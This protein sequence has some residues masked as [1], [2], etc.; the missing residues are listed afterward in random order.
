VSA[1]GSRPARGREESE[2]PANV[3]AFLRRNDPHA[4]FERAAIRARDGESGYAGAVTPE[5]AWL[6][7]RAG[8]ATIVD[9]RTRA[10]WELVGH[11]PGTPLVEWRRYGEESPNPGF[12]AQL[13]DIASRDEPL[14]FLCRSGVRSHHA[15]QAAAQAGF[16][17]AYNNLEGF[18]G[19][20]DD[21]R[22]RGTLG[23]WRR[24]GLPWIQS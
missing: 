11:V 15:A 8:A 21:D 5:E 13:D 22:R 1:V 3:A 24:A 12:L 7:Q 23:G 2:S 6:L 4:V 10:E 14:L 18:E 9:V 19:D 20:L 16:T 17:R